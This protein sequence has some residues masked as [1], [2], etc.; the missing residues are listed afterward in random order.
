MCFQINARK[1]CLHFLWG[2]GQ[3]LSNFMQWRYGQSCH[4]AFLQ[5]NNF[6]ACNFFCAPKALL[7]YLLFKGLEY[8]HKCLKIYF[9]L[10]PKD[11]LRNRGLRGAE[12][13]GGSKVLIVK[14]WM[15]YKTI[16]HCYTEQ[17]IRKPITLTEKRGEGGGRCKRKATQNNN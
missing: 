6:S 10:L 9:N 15:A 17:L 16:H 8:L 3:N 7:Q 14:L 11:D 4:Q 5:G 12:Q 2:R 1:K 13:N